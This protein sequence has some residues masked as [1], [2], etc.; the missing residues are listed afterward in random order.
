MSNDLSQN[1][2]GWSEWHRIGDGYTMA[3]EPGVYVV[4]LTT[5][6]RSPV[7]IPRA[8]GVDQDGIVYIG[9]SSSLSNR[10]GRLLWMTADDIA[11]RQH[12]SLIA[13]W[14]CYD[15]ERLGSRSLLEVRWRF[16][17][18]HKLQERQMIGDYKK[19]YGDIPV[20]NCDTGG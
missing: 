18:D 4:R 17:I 3:Q 8:I 15:L 13:A 6:A 16:C 9:E 11:T 7:A 10:L 2:D 14:I 19:R 1:N 12:H 5:A 20:G